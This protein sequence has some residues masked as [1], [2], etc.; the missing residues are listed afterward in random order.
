MNKHD[1]QCNVKFINE[2]SAK[3]SILFFRNFY[4]IMHNYLHFFFFSTDSE[5]QGTIQNVITL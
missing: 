5:K 2:P 3:R 1:C 4:A